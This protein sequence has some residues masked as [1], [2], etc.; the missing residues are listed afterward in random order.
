MA[1]T[2]LNGNGKYDSITPC[3]EWMNRARQLKWAKTADK[4]KEGYDKI[5]WN[6]NKGEQQ[7]SMNSE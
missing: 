5:V 7:C 4:Y 6:K 3:P 2:P 1:K